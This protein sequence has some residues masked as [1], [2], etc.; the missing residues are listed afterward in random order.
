MSI[1]E[2][3]YSGLQKIIS[4]GQCGADE[5]GL[6]AART[7]G[8][9]TGGWMPAGWRTLNGPKPEFESLY[10]LREH[11]DS[12]YNGRTKA[13]VQDSDGTVIIAQNIASTGTQLTIKYC[14]ALK[15][16]YFIIDIVK[17]KP[18]EQSLKDFVNFVISKNINILNVAGNRDKKADEWQHAQSYNFFLATD[19][20]LYLI[21][22][23]L[24]KNLIVGIK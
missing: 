13:N 6:N 12:S 22:E 11:S 7:M 4:G 20:I 14:V 10:N 9:P 5:G 23:L 2:F 15:K 17:G 21:S 18:T 1:L 8:V 3:D 19:C 24:S 16:P